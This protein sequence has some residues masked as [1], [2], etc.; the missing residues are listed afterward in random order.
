VPFV[1]FP[2]WR[3]SRTPDMSRC[4]GRNLVLATSSCR[5]HGPGQLPGLRLRLRHT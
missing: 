3:R 2:R 4:L 1:S 5:D